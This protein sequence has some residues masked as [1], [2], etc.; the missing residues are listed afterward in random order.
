MF[1]E[2]DSQET[3][4]LDYNLLKIP[5]SI[6]ERCHHGPVDLSAMELFD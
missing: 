6:L 3:R 5:T 2:T 4:V 1:V